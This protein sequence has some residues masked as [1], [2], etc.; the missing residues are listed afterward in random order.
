MKLFGFIVYLY[1]LEMSMDEIRIFVVDLVVF[2]VGC[3]VSRKKNSSHVGQRF[4]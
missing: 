1:H 3:V 4:F 2:F